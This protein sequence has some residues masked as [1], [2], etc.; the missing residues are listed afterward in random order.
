MIDL[1]EI[2][3]FSYYISTFMSENLHPVFVLGVS[4]VIYFI[5]LFYLS[6]AIT[7]YMGR[8]TAADVQM[9]IGPNRVGPFGIFQYVADTLKLFLKQDSVV[10]NRKAWLHLA[11]PVLSIA[12][13]LMAFLSIPVADQWYLANQK[14]SLLH[15]YLLMVAAQLFLF[16]SAYT[17]GNVFGVLSSSRI[18]VAI[19][20]FSVPFLLSIFNIILVS[21]GSSFVEVLAIQ[22]GAPW[23]WM[24]FSYPTTA[25]SF[26]VMYCSLLIWQGA[27]P[28]DILD[29]EE[30]IFGGYSVEYSG[31]RKWFIEQLKSLQLILSCYL[32]TGLFLGGGHFPFNLETFGRGAQAIQSL[33]FSLKV[34][35]LVFISYWIRWSLPRTRLNQVIF[36][37]FKVLIPVSIVGFFLTTVWLALFN[38]KGIGNLL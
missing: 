14:W 5:P 32:L 37:S 36:F 24:L 6:V 27:P 1:Q 34:F 30:E 33:F 7:T 29:S 21:G 25:I 31:S 16:F 26:F 23:K 2:S 28:F 9:R 19:A 20:G 38:G 12:F 13:T 3:P 17:S 4:L 18:L 22:G 11:G 8:K 10:N 35:V 15:V